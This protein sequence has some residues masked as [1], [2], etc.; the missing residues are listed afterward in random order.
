MVSRPSKKNAPRLPVNVMSREFTENKFRYYRWMHEEAPVCQGGLSVMRV[1]FLAGYDDCANA[2]NDP[3]L[4]RNRT[5]ATGGGR[6]LFPLPK[7][8]AP[9]MSS[10][11]TSDDPAHRRQRTLVSKAFTPKALGKLSERIETLTHELIDEAEQRNT[12]DL[13]PAYSLPIPVTVIREMLG[14]DEADMPRFRAGLRALSEGFSGWTVLR[15]LLFDMPRTIDLV[16]ELIE[17]KRSVP[18]DD[19]LTGLIQAEAAG[20]KLSHEELV[21]MSILLIIA[22][23]E[24]TV[25][26]ITNAAVTLLQ[27]PEQFE[28]L[29]AD[30]T[31]LD[32]AVEEILR[33]AGPVHGTKPNYAMEDIEIRGVRIPKGSPVVPLLGAANR[34]PAVFTN[35]EVFDIRRPPK[36]QLGFGHGPHHCLGAAL[37]RMETRIA[38]KTLIERC[39]N[40][41]LAVPAGELKLQRLPLWHRYERLPVILHPEGRR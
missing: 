36:K 27:H 8:L 11:I 17:R 4:V 15:T 14:I 29:K 22:G 19:I 16:E 33:Y 5:T 3:R 12:V 7:R 10:M 9:M 41:R 39:P 40:L 6:F 18:G 21:S 25:H 28:A 2:L 30:G 23:Y 26:L 31:L 20:E 24:T 35:P 34:D 13:I 38:I 1:F 32:A 37:A